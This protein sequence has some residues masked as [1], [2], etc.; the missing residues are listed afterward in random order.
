MKKVIKEVTACKENHRNK[1]ITLPTIIKDISKRKIFFIVV[2]SFMFVLFAV[3]YFV[4]GTYQFF[5]LSSLTPSTFDTIIAFYPYSIYIYI[6]FFP[7]IIIGYIKIV[8]LKENLH[9]FIYSYTI[10]GIVSCII[11]FFYPISLPLEYDLFFQKVEVDPITSRLIKLIYNYDV[12]SNSFPSQ[13][14][15]FI[16][17]IMLHF[18]KSKS[19]LVFH[20]W[21]TLIIFSTLTFKRHYFV[22]IIASITLSSLIH[23]FFYYKVAYYSKQ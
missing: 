13:H 22:D 3:L 21:G 17:L 7:Y 1:V 9:C 14:V 10:S 16:F 18:I 2:S 15:L 6:S 23:C 4:L 5:S 11:F 12:L 8:N 20:F 19:F